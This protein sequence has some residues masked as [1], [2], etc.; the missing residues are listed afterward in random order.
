VAPLAGTVGSGSDGSWDLAGRPGGRWF[1]VVVLPIRGAEYWR[2]ARPTWGNTLPETPRLPCGW[3]YRD[4]A[5]AFDRRSIL[6]WGSRAAWSRYRH[7]ALSIR[8]PCNSTCPPAGLPGIIC[9]SPRDVSCSG[10]GFPRCRESAGLSSSLRCTSPPPARER[11]SQSAGYR[12]PDKKDCI[13]KSECSLRI[14]YIALHIIYISRSY[15]QETRFT[16][17]PMQF[18][19]E[20]YQII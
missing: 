2:T 20:N 15:E 10:L 14:F 11:L 6:S 17:D 9:R 3:A 13:H 18:N 1:L 4:P 5:C 19:N 12:N 16:I 8:L 7:L